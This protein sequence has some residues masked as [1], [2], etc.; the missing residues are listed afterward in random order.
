MEHAA[1]SKTTV[2][3]GLA[4]FP[5]DGFDQEAIVGKALDA[6]LHAVDAGGNRVF[7]F[8]RSRRQSPGG[9]ARV[10]LVDD[11]T[12][13][14]KL[15]GAQIALLGYEP[16]TATSGE[17]AVELVRGIDVDLV[18]LDVMMPG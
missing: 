16:L 15:L 13:D 9:K 4:S 5:E 6:Y 11:D 18:I 12:R 3:I 14:L 7:C 2:S 17:Q 1:K 10:L 8:E